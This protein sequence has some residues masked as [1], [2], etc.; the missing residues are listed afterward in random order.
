MNARLRHGWN[1][2]IKQKNSAGALFTSILNQILII[3]LLFQPLGPFSYPGS[4]SNRILLTFVTV[5]ALVALLIL[6]HRGFFLI[7]NIGAIFFLWL[8][9]SVNL[10]LLGEVNAAIFSAYAVLALWVALTLGIGGAII[11]TIMSVI[12]NLIV[13]YLN[14]MGWISPDLSVRI[15]PMNVWIGQ[16]IIFFA[17][18]LF[19]GQITNQIR[20]AYVKAE[21]ELQK[22]RVTQ[23]ELTRFKEMTER[24]RDIIIVVDLQ[25][26]NLKYGNQAAL[27]AYGYSREEFLTLNIRDIRA[28]QSLSQIEKQMSIASESG[29]LFET[30]HKRKNGSVFPAEVNSRQ[31][32]FDEGTSLI[33]TIRDISWR[34]QVE[35]D[36]HK[37]QAFNL[38][39]L[40]N[41][42][43]LVVV[44]DHEAKITHWNHACRQLS[45]YDAPEVLGHYVW[46][47][48]LPPENVEII[49]NR[50]RLN[51]VQHTPRHFENEWVT[52]SGERRQIAWNSN[53]LLDDDGQVMYIIDTGQDITEQ[54]HMQI[55]LAESEALFRSVFEQAAVGILIATPEAIMTNINERLCQILGYT[56]E[57]LIGHNINEFCHPDDRQQNQVDSNELVQGHIYRGVWERR[58]LHK[59]GSIV[60]TNAAVTLLRD[61]YGAP[62][63][64]LSIIED[65]SN[66]KQAEAELKSN[67]QR[68]QAQI[69]LNQLTGH[70]L[71]ELADFSLEEAVRLTDSQIGFI[72]T[73]NEDENK[74]V[75]LAG[76]AGNDRGM[77]LHD[78]TGNPNDYH[79][80]IFEYV[81]QNRS[82]TIIN[83]F[84]QREA[85]E[86]THP[87]EG[88]DRIKNLLLM[89][90]IDDRKIVLVAAV[91]N[92]KYNYNDLDQH[93]L[94]LLMEGMWQI[95]KRSQAEKELQELN[96][97]L[98]KRVQ[99]RTARLEAINKELEAFSYS[100]S[101]DLR[102]PLRSM[103]GFSQ[104]LRED[105]SDFLPPAA[106]QYLERIENAAGR[107]NQLIE[108]LLRFS[109]LG[110]YP[111]N[112]Q[113]IDI[114]SLAHTT[115]DEMS[116]ERNDRD[117]EYI[118]EKLPAC[119]ADPALIKQVFSNL[120]SNAIKYTRPVK[121]SKITL[122][123]SNIDN[124]MVY[125]I[126]DNGVGFD[127]QY[128]DRLFGVFQRLHSDRQFEGTG[129]GLAIVQRIINRH[130]GRIWF[131]AHIDQGATFYFTFPDKNSSGG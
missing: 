123:C 99:E 35:K 36:L 84:E 82:P 11:F 88:H 97:E 125:W 2:L 118:Q 131:D 28:P 34:K 8:F 79:S 65:I 87:P 14:Q 124:Q 50:V 117:I 61:E 64:F 10:L 56:S 13:A 16:T 115:W 108:D 128:A 77:N 101:H 20:K 38:A 32:D 122:G 83:N 70:N 37:E 21:T 7:A 113:Y 63:M 54:R 5:I 94:T 55:A 121:P 49:K 96:T 15:T 6:L 33:S 69:Q 66:L 43:S 107:M 31:F 129:V 3:S 68:M 95:F 4:F 72:A 71:N 89:P 24:A 40:G 116:V 75:M 62:L 22:H 106:Q 74:L 73:V 111:L 81:L 41:I 45:G 93:Q 58:Y 127:M 114:D 57:E 76:Y 46:E 26:G 85:L 126:K 109:R 120:F 27:S 100:I 44:F 90:I 98:E 12:P 19:A 53:Y 18:I 119:Y 59:N 104:A 91:A 78:W 9:I 102:A 48:L 130:G 80:E 17:V 39:I 42:G 1:D 103:S 92:K 30:R 67:I 52:K 23:K 29:I 86:L 25:S 47:F 51:F 112:I 110:R 60:W 105:Y